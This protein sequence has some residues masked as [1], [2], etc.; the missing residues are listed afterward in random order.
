M[1]PIKIEDAIALAKT[2][3]VYRVCKKTLKINPRFMNLNLR[4]DANIKF[5]ERQCLSSYRMYRWMP[6]KGIQFIGQIYKAMSK[7]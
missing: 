3:I 6:E 4:Y 7:K 1:T 5:Y 2:K